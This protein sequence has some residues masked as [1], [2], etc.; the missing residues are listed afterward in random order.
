MGLAEMLEPIIRLLLLVTYGVYV[1]FGLLI[2]VLGGVYL[3][4]I[5]GADATA[6]G[7]CIACGL[8]MMLV[9]AG[10]VY[11][12]LNT[13][14]LI[15]FAVLIIDVALFCAL[16]AA[17]MVGFVIANEVKDPVKRGVDEAYKTVLLRTNS[18]EGI[19]RGIKESVGGMPATCKNFD[20]ELGDLTSSA[21]RTYHG[22]VYL[23]KEIAGNCTLAHNVAGGGYALAKQCE[24]CWHDFRHHM[25]VNIKK[26]L[27][28]AT[29][30]TFSLFGFVV[31]SIMLNM[32]MID[33]CDPDDEDEDE[34]APDKWAPQ[35][36]IQLLSYVL[37]GLVGLFGL[38]MLI[39]GIMAYSELTS[40]DCPAES[41]CTNWA[42]VG[43]VLLGAFFFL[44]GILNGAAVFLGGF[45]GKSIVRI[46]TIVWTGLAFVLL[47]V[48]I[49][50]ALVAGA[51]TSINEE[52]DNNFSK[53]REQATEAEPSIC[54]S[55]MSDAECKTKIKEETQD[56]FATIGIVLG[57]TCAGFV[58]VM[59]IT[60]LAVK[61]WRAGDDDDDEDGDE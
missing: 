60:L 27:W 28:P 1:A 32:Y 8:F 2:C 58:F 18:W 37:S 46:M 43:I 42:V 39:A 49:C 25:V 33:N 30:T 47:L 48:G 52:Y 3:S 57:I 9:G 11:A 5:N 20:D 22:I 6:A 44:L 17:C 51:I 61:L 56:A 59:Y 4:E 55:T 7:I 40:S 15:M 13:N 16:L 50:F 36:G 19:E 54:P 38:L 14:W 53:I 31:I 10:A 26:H 34:D 35:G 45:I 24:H 21:T 41:D 12:T 23:E 29:Y